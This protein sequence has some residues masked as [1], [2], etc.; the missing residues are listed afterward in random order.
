MEDFLLHEY[1]QASAL[2]Y[3]EWA[4]AQVGI[5]NTLITLGAWSHIKSAIASPQ[6]HEYMDFA[7]PDKL[8][9]AFNPANCHDVAD[10]LYFGVTE[11][12]SDTLKD[13]CENGLH[14]VAEL[15]GA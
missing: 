5:F 14:K 15:V 4:N 8:V 12:H 7:I 1:N 13:Q 2:G 10:I 6:S 3:N 9:E 11:A